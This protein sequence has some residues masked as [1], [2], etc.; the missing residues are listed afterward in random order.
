MQTR[1]AKKIFVKN[2][3][4]TAVSQAKTD[5]VRMEKTEFKIEDGQLVG[6]DFYVR[7]NVF[8]LKQPLVASGSD[9][10]RIWIKKSSTRKIHFFN[11]GDPHLTV[12]FEHSVTFPQRGKTLQEFEALNEFCL[13]LRDILGLEK[14]WVTEDDQPPPD[15]LEEAIQAKK[16][17]EEENCSLKLR[18]EETEKKLSK[19]QDKLRS[20]V[21]DVEK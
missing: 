19:M 13:M 1:V 21:E 2:L 4:L 9:N 15:Q 3:D 18:L 20:F 14:E 10:Y 7:L 16:T 17:V 5:K 8:G 6:A 11:I 12:D